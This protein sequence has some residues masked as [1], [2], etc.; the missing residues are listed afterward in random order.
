MRAALPEAEPDG[1]L[2]GRPRGRALVLG[3]VVAALALF[4]GVAPA[5]A[6]S[7]APEPETS[8]APELASAAEPAPEPEAEPAGRAVAAEAP[9]LEASLIAC[10]LLGASDI[11]V[12]ASGL[13]S[14]AYP[15]GVSAGGSPVPGVPNDALTASN[16][17]TVFADLPNGGEYV[18]WLKDSTGHTVATTSIALPV[19]DLPTLDDPVVG[20][21]GDDA[22]PGTRTLAP[23]G[24][25]AVGLLLVGLGA[26]QGGAL[27]AGL[28]A[29]RR[30]R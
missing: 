24:L 18:V 8:V 28:G 7:V 10:D 3:L 5:A 20:A 19:C 1:R 30:R 25:P 26:L 11:T 27:A 9:G 15:A 2:A 22:A 29:L 21:D 13:G 23:T 6:D 14:G 17:T 12:S 4:S 16:S